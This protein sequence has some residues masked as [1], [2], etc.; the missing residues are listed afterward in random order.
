MSSNDVKRLARQCSKITPTAAPP[1]ATSSTRN[2][3]FESS[4]RTS[5]SGFESG[6][7]SHEKDANLDQLLSCLSWSMESLEAKLKDT[8][9]QTDFERPLPVRSPT[10][11]SITS[12]DFVSG[13][14]DPEAEPET[15][16]TSPVNGEPRSVIQQVLTKDAR[17][18]SFLVGSVGSQDG[19]L[20]NDEL[21]RYFPSGQMSLLT[22][23]W[24]MNSKA[25]PGDI[26]D[27]LLPEQL[28][29]LPDM[30][31][32]GIQEGVSSSS[33]DI[34]EMEVHLQTTI[35]PSH[36]LLHSVALGVLHL[37]IFVRRDIVWFFSQPEDGVYNSRNSSINMVKTKGAVGVSF[38]LFGTSFL[39]VNSHLPAHAER[40]KE[41]CHEYNK[42][43]HSL[44]LPRNLRP[45]KPRYVSRD[46]TNRFDVVIWMGDLNF[47]VDRPLEE[48]V[49]TVKQIRGSSATHNTKTYEI[50][51]RYDQLTLCLKKK[52]V[53]S[54]F[55]EAA[56]LTFPPTFKYVPDTD[57]YDK[58]SQ[59]VPSWTDRVLF[60]AKRSA[61]VTCT[62]YNSIPEIKSSDHRPVFA[63]MDIQLKPGRDNVPLNAGQFNREIYV[64]SLKRRATDSS[65]KDRRSSLVCSIS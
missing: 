54:G 25:P 60:K 38:V 2:A 53:F 55:T 59:R 56:K 17:T 62:T 65:T 61:Y 3:T 26:N 40:V 5:T 24:N 19:L 46:V 30:Y 11:K 7:T 39:F 23:T 37:T 21:S 22:L 13:G 4:S 51:T 52:L 31:A 36:V 1:S 27:L 20:G 28:L 14:S 10:F 9:T 57:D 63:V 32:I 44:D 18:R 33:G 29:Y 8:G 45:L 34:R 49:N 35:G 50:L 58:G 64:E 42:I 12:D 47:R 43:V 41:R 15:P 48:V 16:A 6:D